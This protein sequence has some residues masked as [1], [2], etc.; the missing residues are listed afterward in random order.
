[1]SLFGFMAG[2]TPDMI[3][4]QGRSRL[5][6]PKILEALRPEHCTRHGYGDTKK[7]G[8][9]EYIHVAQKVKVVEDDLSGDPVIIL[10]TSSKEFVQEALLCRNSAVNNPNKNC[11]SSLSAGLSKCPSYMNPCQIENQ[12]C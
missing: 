9:K 5:F 10:I 1:M 7:N 6:S 11:S 8:Q 12:M 2:R 3:L 4:T